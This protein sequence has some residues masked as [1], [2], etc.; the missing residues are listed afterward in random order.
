[1]SWTRRLRRTAGAGLLVVTA[2]VALLGFTSE[3]ASRTSTRAPSGCGALP[4]HTTADIGR[5]V[6]DR[7]PRTAAV[8]VVDHAVARGVDVRGAIADLRALH[9][10]LRVRVRSTL[11]STGIDVEVLSDGDVDV[12]LTALDALMRVPLEHHE[13]V[14][15]PRLAA[16]LACYHR[17]IVAEREFAGTRLRLVVPADPRTCFRAGRLVVDGTNSDRLRCNAAGFTLPGAAELRVFGLDIVRLSSPPTIVVTP[18][19]DPTSADPAGVL[20][21]LLTHELV[22]H[23]DN[24]MGLLPWTGSLA[25]Y[26]QRAYYV[27]RSVARARRGEPLPRAIR[28]P[29]ADQGAAP[30]G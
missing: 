26:E 8:T 13:H 22:H 9:Q 16:V 24:Q 4:A 20:A 25:G 27:E 15:D 30:R 29:T 23:Y 1:M 2:G 10:R 17:R 11:P 21:R 18:G 14:E 7:V 28:F 3:G 19:I 6:T 12:D 5:R